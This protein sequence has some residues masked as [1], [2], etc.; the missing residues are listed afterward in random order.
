MSSHL[1]LQTLAVHAGRD[2]DQASGAVAAAIAPSVTFQR[3]A[4]GHYP[5]G[6]FLKRMAV[7]HEP[8]LE[9]AACLR[10]WQ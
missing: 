8:R 2:I 7:M 1:R 3:D 6:Y 5:L 10:A 9:F 4:E